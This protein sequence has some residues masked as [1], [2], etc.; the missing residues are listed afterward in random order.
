MIADELEDLAVLLEARNRKAG[1]KVLHV[2]AFAGFDKYGKPIDPIDVLPGSDLYL[3]RPE[4]PGAGMLFPG[5]PAGLPYSIDGRQFAH[6]EQSGSTLGRLYAT[7]LE[8]LEAG[9]IGE[10]QAILYKK[11]WQTD[12]D[13]C[14]IC[15]ENATAGW[16]LADET[17]PSGDEEPDAHPNCKCELIVQRDD[18]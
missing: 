9:K 8:T 11:R 4:D 18:A 17:F 5:E 12:D 2:A 6:P 13:P 7:A 1:R 14:D 15:L 10:I 3:R 16:I